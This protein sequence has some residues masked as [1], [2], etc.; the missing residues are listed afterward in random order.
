MKKFH[1]STNENEVWEDCTAIS[2]V[3]NT[4]PINRLWYFDGYY[5][6]I[7]EA[8]NFEK[9]VKQAELLKKLH[10]TQLHN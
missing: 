9:A 5:A 8:D 1:L 10:P 7:V 3:V 6:V 2:S 4:H